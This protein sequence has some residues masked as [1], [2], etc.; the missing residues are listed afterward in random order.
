M[1]VLIHLLALSA[2]CAA[3]FA[4]DDDLP[5][6]LD[7]ND[8]D[9]DITCNDGTD[10]CDLDRRGV[11][12]VLDI[13][14]GGAGGDGQIGWGLW[15]CNSKDNKKECSASKDRLTHEVCTRYCKCAPK[16]GTYSCKKFNDCTDKQVSSWLQVPYPVEPLY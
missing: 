5:Q 8:P 3:G 1:R 12:G 6:S 16:T 4:A 10:T 14:A 2:F 11:G 7:T 9:S 15:Y 13:G